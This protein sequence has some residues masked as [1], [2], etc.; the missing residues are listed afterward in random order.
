ML[1][2]LLNFL[3]F[4]FNFFKNLFL[5]KIWLK[6]IFATGSGS[7]SLIFFVHVINKSLIKRN[8]K[9]VNSDANT[10][11]LIMALVRLSQL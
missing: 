4:F 2:K 5:F 9:T 10:G 8:I 7:S 11:F 1:L 3:N 6:S